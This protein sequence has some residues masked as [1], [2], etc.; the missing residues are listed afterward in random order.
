MKIIYIAGMS[1][2][3]S[4]LLSLMLNAHPKIC[5]AGELIDLHRVTKRK[6]GPSCACGAS[7]LWGCEF[8]LGVNE[9]MLRAEGMSLA[10][11]DGTIGR[12]FGE[13]SSPTARVLRAV[14][15]VSGKGFIV[16]S[17]KRPARLSYLLQLKDLNVFPVHLIR[18]PMGQVSSLRRKHGGFT[19]H[20]FDY[21]RVHEEIRRMLRSVHHSVIYY[22]DLVRDPEGTLGSIL[23]PLG[24]QF[25]PAQLRWTEQRQH[26]LAG[27]KLRWQPNALIL[28]ERWKESLSPAK[29]FI[30]G[31]GTA[32]SKRR[33]S[34]SSRQQL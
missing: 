15:A 18:D 13:G 31:L 24:L 30:I 19:R 28:D 4:T 32:Y 29:R 17:S 21:L 26:T 1:H 20:I 25:D 9:W 14:S 27:N 10:D 7:S 5:S 33:L 6:S 16:D 11:L 23:K 3:G 22:E 8:W 34:S 12:R 2:S